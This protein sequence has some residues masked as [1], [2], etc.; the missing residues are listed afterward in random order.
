MEEVEV[1]ATIHTMAEAVFKIKIFPLI[2]LEI[3][4]INLS[5]LI[6]KFVEKLDIWPWIAITEWTTTIKVVILQQN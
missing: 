2:L 4:V 1:D 5:V 3:L 6:V